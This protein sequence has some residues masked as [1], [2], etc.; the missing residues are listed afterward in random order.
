M[1]LESHRRQI[2]DVYDLVLYYVC[3]YACMYVMSVVGGEI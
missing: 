2:L 3:V 1:A